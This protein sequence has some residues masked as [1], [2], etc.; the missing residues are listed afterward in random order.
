M[1]DS[2]YQQKKMN[3]YEWRIRSLAKGVDPD[4]AIKE[5]ERIESVYGTL[6]PERILNESRDDSAVLHPLFEWEDDLAAEKF[7]IHQAR[8][9]L[10]NIHVKIIKD[11]SSSSFPVYE[12]VNINSER[13]YRSIEVMTQ[14]DIEQVKKATL[15]DLASIKNKLEAYEN[16]SQ[17]IGHISDAMGTLQWM[18]LGKEGDNRYGSLRYG[19]ADWVLRGRFGVLVSVQFCYGRYGRV[20]SGC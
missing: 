12:V 16:F 10:N 17:T 9:I 19:K 14:S 13:R 8:F 15:K 4:D 1:E 5:L 2:N 18:C 6:S 20:L 11:G 7:R 3:K